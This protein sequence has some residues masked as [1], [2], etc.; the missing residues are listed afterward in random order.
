[1]GLSL[2]YAHRAIDGAPA[3][4]FVQELCRQLEQFTVLLAK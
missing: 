4:R 1:M 2:T 3:S